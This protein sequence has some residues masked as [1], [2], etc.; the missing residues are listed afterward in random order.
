[1]CGILGINSKHDVINRLMLGLHRLEYRGYDSAGISFINS[2]GLQTIKNLGKVKDL[3]NALAKLSPHGDIGI[4][5]TRW[6]THGLPCDKNAHPHSNGKVSV[7]HNGIIENHQALRQMLLDTGVKFS[8]DTDSEVITH[9]IAMYLYKGKNLVQATRC[10]MNQLIGAFGILVLSK[11][12]P[13]VMV[14]AKRHASICVGLGTDG[15]FIGS[16]SYALSNFVDSVQYLEDDDVV[17]CGKDQFKILD[18]RD[19]AVERKVVQIKSAD[20]H[21]EKGLFAHYMQK[22]IFEQPLSAKTTLENYINKD[23][24]LSSK[25][26]GIKF[27]NVKR[28]YIVACGT[29][30]FAGMIMKHWLQEMAQIRVEIELASEF[31]YRNLLPEED[32]V[33][34]F[35]S[36]SG[37]TADT[38]AG[39][40]F[41]NRSNGFSI[42]IV[43]NAEST[44]GRESRMCL[45]IYAGPEVGVATTKA[46]TSMLVVLACLAIKASIEKGL[47]DEQTKIK[48]IQKLCEVPGRISALLNREQEF[49]D[50]ASLIANK[51]SVLYLGRGIS[52]A[53]ACE[54]ALKLKELSYIHAEAIAAGEL[55]HGP[56]ALVDEEMYAIVVAPQDKL[57]LKTMSNV[58][59]VAA[60]KGNIILLSSATG[61]SFAQGLCKTVPVDC[62]EDS[63]QF[64]MPIIYSIPL[65]IIAYHAAV[66]RGNNVDQPRNLA[67]SV[68]VE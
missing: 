47:M 46:F 12:N 5:H 16:D 24:G 44:I 17:I 57:F 28:V 15:T 55:K 50:V 61:C 56:I 32:S 37:E 68:T 63:S 20:R 26:D 54:G 36:Q 66:I 7:I 49:Y 53:L 13:S 67:K 3:E 4:A 52:Y 33:G 45:P 19:A 34:I 23:G 58:Q 6:A 21:Y 64:V 18:V 25:L 30:F 14:A 48:H 38:I 10:A 40:R 60:R 62:D 11:D 42:S 9:L 43:N 2:T 59:V 65:Q 1:M 8:S 51:R 35:I 41:F 27:K 31:C 39:L 29:S 22:E